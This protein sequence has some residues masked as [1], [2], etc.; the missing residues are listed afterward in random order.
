[1]IRE[2]LIEELKFLN[3][4]WCS[5]CTN[6]HAQST[7]E[8]AFWKANSCLLD[9]SKIIQTLTLQISKI[10]SRNSNTS[11]YSESAGMYPLNTLW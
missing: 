3:L 2:S 9:S 5:K 11:A 6:F 1:M 8:S 10:V 7:S 4:G